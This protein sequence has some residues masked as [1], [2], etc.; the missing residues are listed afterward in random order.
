MEILSFC[1][2]NQLRQLRGYDFFYI[3]YETID[4]LCIRVI[5]SCKCYR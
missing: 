5:N 1:T 3:V 2:G 4:E